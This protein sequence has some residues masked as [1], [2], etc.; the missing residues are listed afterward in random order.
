MYKLLYPSIRVRT[1][2]PSPVSVRVMTRV[3]FSFNVLHVSLGPLRLCDSGPESSKHDWLYF[4]ISYGKER[5]TNVLNLL[6]NVN[7]VS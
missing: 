1:A 5:K 3:S 7:A 4:S 2:P 6:V